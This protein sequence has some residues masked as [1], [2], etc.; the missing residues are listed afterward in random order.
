MQVLGIV[1][2][3]IQDGYKLVADLEG[4]NFMLRTPWKNILIQ[5]SLLVFNAQIVSSEVNRG[6]L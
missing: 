6:M 3:I 4:F 2:R 5:S 1:G